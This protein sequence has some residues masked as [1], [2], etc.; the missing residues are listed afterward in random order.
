MQRYLRLTRCCQFCKADPLRGSE[1]CCIS[2]IPQQV[3]SLPS[4]GVL[5][6]EPLRG[7]TYMR[8][9]DG[10]SEAPTGLGM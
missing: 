8:V 5:H 10:E 3:A 2:L 4:W 7:S 6:A 1:V 9:E